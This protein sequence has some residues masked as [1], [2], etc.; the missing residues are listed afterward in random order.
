MRPR[1]LDYQ[2]EQIG[3]AIAHVVSLRDRA[4]S[5]ADDVFGAVPE[6]KGSLD[7][8]SNAVGR[9]HIMTADIQVLHDILSSLSVEID[10]L[11]CL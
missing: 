1:T 11:T 8:P 4:R 6:G 5:I 9:S 3:A 2:R 7:K 10:R